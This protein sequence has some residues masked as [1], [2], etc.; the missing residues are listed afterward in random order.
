MSDPNVSI[1]FDSD[2]SAAIAANN[3]LI[4]SL[5][6]L[7]AQHAA[8][9]N[10]F[11]GGLGDVKAK[12]Q[13][14]S[15]STTR[16]SSRRNP[17]PSS[18]PP[19]ELPRLRSLGR[20]GGQDLTAGLDYAKAVSNL[21]KRASDF[22][23]IKSI[24]VPNAIPPIADATKK[25][26][27]LSTSAI[28]SNSAFSAMGSS[29]RSLAGQAAAFTGLSL[30]AAALG[31]EIRKAIQAVSDLDTAM[32]A[33]AAVGGLDKTGAEMATL[34]QQVMELGSKTQYGAVG[35]AEGLKEL[36]AAG[37]SSSDASKLLADTLALAATE[38]MG[39]GRASEIVV[40]G[41][42]A[43]G[44]SV[45]EGTR[46]SD[47]LARSANA[48]TASVD[49]MGE[50]LKYAA[51]VSKALGVTLEETNA[52]LAILANNGIRGGAA[53]RGLSSVMA[54]M[55]APTKDAV[56]AL[57]ELGMSANDINPMVVGVEASLKRLASLPQVQLVKMFGVE[58]LDVSNILKAN[59]D[60]FAEM[61]EYMTKA[62]VS[63]KSM[64]EIRMDNLAGDMKKLGAALTEL[65][66]EL[67][68]ENYESIRDVVQDFTAYLRENKD[69]I[70]ENAKK[71]GDLA[72]T[73]GQVVTA[74]AAVKGVQIIGHLVQTIAKWAFETKM[75]DANTAALGRNATARGAV[76]SAGAGGGVVP[77]LDNSK[78]GKGGKGGKL[79]GFG[80]LIAPTIG[81]MV[82]QE[83]APEDAGTM[84]TI[85]YGLGG[86]ALATG[87]QKGIGAVAR[88]AMA[89]AMAKITA[90]AGAGSAASAAGATLAK[91][92]AVGVVG[93][94][95]FITAAVAAP[96]AAAVYVWDAHKTAA[97]R[98][99]NSINEYGSAAISASNRMVRAAK[100]KNALLEAEQFIMREI[101]NIEEQKKQLAEEGGA[102]A[103]EQIRNLTLT[104]QALTQIYNNSEKINQR[105]QENIRL[106]QEQAKAAEELKK[107]DEE[108]ARLGA[109]HTENLRKQA[110]YAAEFSS[111][112][113]GRRD[114]AVGELSEG[115]QLKVAGEDFSAAKENVA[116]L[117]KNMQEAV[118]NYRDMSKIDLAESLV[119]MRFD[120]AEDFKD[121]IKAAEEFSN[122]KA[123]EFS[124][125]ENMASYYKEVLEQAKKSGDVGLMG[126]IEPFIQELDKAV[127]ASA[128]ARKKIDQT[129]TQRNAQV[130][131]L[132][133]TSEQGAIAEGSFNDA[134]DGAK[135][136]R[137]QIDAILKSQGI[138]PLVDPKKELKNA[139][140]IAEYYRKTVEA[141][142]LLGRNDL[143][144]AEP[145]T[146]LAANM[147]KAD[148]ASKEQD[149]VKGVQDS[150]AMQMKQMEMQEATANN[151][152]RRAAQLGAELDLMKEQ[153]SIASAMNLTGK[154]GQAEAKR[155]A[156]RKIGADLRVD[157]NEKTA[158]MNPFGSGPRQLG[159]GATAMNQLFGRSSNS[160]LLENAKEQSRYLK[161]LVELAKIKERIQYV[162][163]IS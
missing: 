151:D 45:E 54:K 44:L 115:G 143:I 73:L 15:E 149:R 161:E 135:V 65:R 81:F 82:G 12:V 3:A 101:K 118:A 57:K 71:I 100:D 37:Y 64:S 75:I 17:A 126:T 20:L 103:K 67:V 22:R 163:T 43:F 162:A 30:G 113:E 120:L 119:G 72:I 8:V 69:V 147:N 109:I 110:E 134:I 66:I 111:N 102:G 55:V 35:A 141:L 96:I 152:P 61:N 16:S 13:T 74:Y 51:P 92:L 27:E 139:Q 131:S 28:T 98:A 63:A 97:N 114:S 39:M 24:V 59:A 60:G 132:L 50:A 70:A 62:N 86:A 21:G 6:K 1:K 77:T 157:L 36:I 122:I 83:V 26:G 155:L 76:T 156:A 5:K 128:E 32:S 159:S 78:G 104:Q 146:D 158:E 52:V 153:A 133:P 129:L 142:N 136:A 42:Q 145:F 87:L 160:G 108:R 53:G 33:V 23:P 121:A 106:K 112:Y 85:G 4:E 48:S 68:G 116:T 137:D 84:E 154:E 49:D 56:D 130:V 95:G 107:I 150:R 25:V 31:N 18:E 124:S 148:A 41:L 14:S 7:E 29:L 138:E 99:F 2:S 79:G 34:T 38:S 90:G 58:N 40:A 88:P 140:D 117:R 144:T 10:S 11:K 93:S 46:L 91:G 127:K 94:A 80:N 19:V 105:E 89:A 9:K 125:V 47:V 123:P